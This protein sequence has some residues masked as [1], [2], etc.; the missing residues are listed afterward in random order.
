MDDA[1]D[2]RADGPGVAR[3]L[4]VDDSSVQRRH[5]LTLARQLGVGRVDAAADG[6]EALQ[7]LRRLPNVPDLMIIDL[8]MPTMDGVELIQRLQQLPRCPPFVVASARE[9][10]L[11]GA[12]EEMAREPHRRRVILESAL[13][14]AQRLDLVTVAEDVET[15]DDRML[16]RCYGCKVAQGYLI[17]RPMPA[18]ELPAWLQSHQRHRPALRAT[19][20]RER[21]TTT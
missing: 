4:V 5:L 11:V 21:T 2:D 16:L 3:L 1:P 20:R 14:M 17:S 9:S 18:V 8:A 19:A 13:E 15:L 6:A 10:L 7:L 12:V